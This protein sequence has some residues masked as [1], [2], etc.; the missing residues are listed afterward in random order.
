MKVQSVDT[1][2]GFSVIEIII[3][4]IVIG[5]LATLAILGY[6]GVKNTAEMAELQKDAS[7][8]A[9]QIEFLRDG[10]NGSSYPTSLAGVKMNPKLTY[11]YINM[12]TT[13]SYCINVTSAT[14]GSFHFT[15]TE[16]VESGECVFSTVSKIAA[17]ELH[18]CVVIDTKAKCW[19]YN[20]YGKLG[21]GSTTSASV[22]VQVAG[23]T[24]VTDISLG[25]DHTCAVNAG[26]VYCW[27]YGGLGSLGNGS[28]ANSV[29]PV[30]ASG[31]SG[32][33]DLDAGGYH[34]CA[35]SGGQVYCWG[36]NSDGELGIGSTATATTPTLVAG[37]SNITSVTAGMWHTC[38]L[39][40]GGLVYCWGDA[41][42]LGNGTS[43]D[44]TTPVQASGLSGVTKIAG[45]YIQTCAVITTNQQM[46]CW[47]S[48][49][50]GILGNGTFTGSAL[51]PVSTP[52]M[53]S[54]TALIDGSNA[55]H[56]CA[57]KTNQLYCWGNGG[58]AQL[59]TGNYSNLAVPTSI[60]QPTSVKAVT[61][62]TY[63]SCAVKTNN[64]VYCWGYGDSGLLGNGA[65]TSSP[66]PVRVLL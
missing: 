30:I 3:V 55:W 38:A 22:P 33:T 64:L 21:D 43:V 1:R 40:S 65:T 12:L 9:K 35:V 26:Q 18:T 47:G 42:R 57:L 50:Y 36:R 4:I 23:L 63:H 62:G 16:T 14:L 32:V 53:S 45:G 39:T 5:I 19:G 61:G 10:V 46:Y 48:N 8:V 51:T 44:S 60:A 25:S 49:T 13:S 31:L 17:G 11:E 20:T 29:S 34:T 58:D 15:P 6:R 37:L 24:S 66:T 54:V 56:E 41:G 7:D 52:G 59:G 27:G 28:T 2:H